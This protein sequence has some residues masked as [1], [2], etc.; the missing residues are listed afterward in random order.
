MLSQWS[1]LIG[2][3]SSDIAGLVCLESGKPMADALV[4][5]NYA[6]SFVNLYAGMH[7]NGMVLPSQTKNHMLLATKE[8]G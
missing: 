4:E 5:M 6:R 8:V 2:K 1:D 3:H 7:S